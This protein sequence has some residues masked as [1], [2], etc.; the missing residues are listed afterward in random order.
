MTKSGHYDFSGI[1]LKYEIVGR[2][3][4]YYVEGKE[5][6][7]WMIDKEGRKRVLK[8]IEKDLK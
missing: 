3:T 2:R 1:K 6:K 7:H 8:I 4:A 5:V